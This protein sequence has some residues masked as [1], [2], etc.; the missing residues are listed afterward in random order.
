MQVEKQKLTK[1]EHWDPAVR[2]DAEAGLINQGGAS[3]HTKGPPVLLPVPPWNQQ[4]TAYSGS[5][6][7]QHLIPPKMHLSLILHL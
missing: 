3:A 1:P 7:L 6:A 5:R 4:G 2:M